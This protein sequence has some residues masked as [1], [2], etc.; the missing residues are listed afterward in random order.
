[1]QARVDFPAVPF[2]MQADGLC[3]AGL[4]SFLGAEGRGHKAKQAA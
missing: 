1:M 4:G 2:S 3:F